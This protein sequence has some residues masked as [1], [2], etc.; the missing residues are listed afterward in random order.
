MASEP[1]EWQYDR[2]VGRGLQEVRR[3]WPVSKAWAYPL[4]PGNRAFASAISRADRRPMTDGSSCVP[5]NRAKRISVVARSAR[6]RAGAKQDL[7]KWLT[8]TSVGGLIRPLRGR[9]SPCPRRAITRC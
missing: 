3:L 7:S 6:C 1:I 2:H 9:W 5:R 8:P 4:S